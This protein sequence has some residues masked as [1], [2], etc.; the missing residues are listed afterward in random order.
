[1]PTHVVL[2]GDYDMST[3]GFTVRNIQP[4]INKKEILTNMRQ[5]CVEGKNP[6]LLLLPRLDLHRLVQVITRLG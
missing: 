6:M 2:E 5:N 3:G 4:L 1:M